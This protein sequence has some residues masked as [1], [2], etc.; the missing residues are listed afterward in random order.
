MNK[1]NNKK[2]VLNDNY[3]NYSIKNIIITFICVLAFLAIF[4]FIT[5]I[6]VKDKNDEEQQTEVSYE[7]SKILVSQLL[8]K[9]ESEYYVLATTAK[10]D[11]DMKEVYETYYATY[12]KD[13]DTVLYYI[14]LDD[15]MNSNYVTEEDNITD[16]LTK[17]T[18]SQDTFFV[19]VDGHISVAYSGYS[20]IVKY[21]KNANNE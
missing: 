2:I 8:S 13:D 20:E 16:D 18:V 7:K 10:E 11:S 15:A 17:L 21:I 5:V 9:P 14:N 19:I 4:Y 1:Q 6:V 12:L 3:D